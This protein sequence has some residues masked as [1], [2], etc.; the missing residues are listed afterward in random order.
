MPA[1]NHAC[2]ADYTRDMENPSRPWLRT[3]LNFLSAV[4]LLLLFIVIANEVI[5]E[6]EFGLDNLV[7]AWMAAHTSHKLTSVMEVVTF[8][9]SIFFLFPAFLLVGFWLYRSKATTAALYFLFTASIGTLFLYA[10]KYFFHRNRPDIA[11]IHPESGYSFPSGHAT[12]SVI[13]FGWLGYLIVSRFSLG[14]RAQWLLG[15]LVILICISIGISRVYLEV[16]YASDV[17]AGYCLGASY[18]LTSFLLGRKIMDQVFK[19]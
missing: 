13:F 4:G 8:F 2:A 19:R 17:L 3:L 9:G 1:P 11:L 14:T 5:R 10:A 16:H 6:K 7:D 18:F 12:C 15:L